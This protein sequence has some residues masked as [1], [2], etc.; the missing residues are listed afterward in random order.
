M[1]H[2]ANGRLFGGPLVKVPGIPRKLLP[3]LMILAAVAIL[4]ALALMSYQILD[5]AYG[6]G[7]P[8]YG[9]T[10]NMDKWSDPG[11]RLIAI[12]GIGLA[13]A[14]VL[15]WLGLRGLGR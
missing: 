2:S 8:Y 1:P 11:P 13:G 6:S 9:R 7:P 14:G 4:I 3:I 10:T 5:E 12:C 15:L